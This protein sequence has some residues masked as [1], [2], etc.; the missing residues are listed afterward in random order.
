MS[1]PPRRTVRLRVLVV[2][3]TVMVLGF[4]LTGLVTFLLQ[5][6][7]LEDNVRGQLDQEVAELRTAAEYRAQDPGARTGV[8]N[9]LQAVT[10]SSAPSDHEAVLA[11][12]DGT[13]AYRPV[14]QDFDLA[15]PETLQQVREAYVPGRTVHTTLDVRGRTVRSVIASVRV[16]G[17]PAEGIFVVGIDVGPQHREIWQRAGA[18][19]AAAA[20]S[21]LIAGT[22]GALLIGRLLRPLETLRRAAE[23]VTHTDLSRRV[24]VPPTD[25][26]V[27]ALALT[28]NGMLERL[29][30]AFDG[31]RQF[32]RDAGHE[33]RTPLTVVQGTLETTDPD[34]P[35]DVRESREIALEELERMS[36]LVGDLSELARAGRPDFLTPR[37]VDLDLFAQSLL[38]RAEHLGGDHHWLLEDSP[39]GVAE[40]DDQRLAQ[41]VLQLA[42]NAVRYSPPGTTVTLGVHRR[43]ADRT[44]HGEILEVH[45]DDEGP[46][47][48]EHERERIFDRFA[49]G[50]GVTD[51]AGTGLGLP[52]VRAIA[53]AHGG[54]AHVTAA[55]GGGARFVLRVPSR[56]S[57]T[58]GATDDPHP[59]NPDPVPEPAPESPGERP[60]ENPD[61]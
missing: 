61:R 53:Q 40:F 2:M 54:S 12:V 5:V 24:P 36:R 31:Q 16:E 55:P 57:R 20:A 1:T 60:D 43:P 39:A 52:I 56:G 30:D 28:V 46:G 34:D 49:R 29:E 22:V 13:P 14:E 26:D 9:L 37:P 35:A 38:A 17:D 25:D 4:L 10:R 33:L 23:E 41:A 27:A 19:A 44:E 45:V 8:A 15:D 42:A 47:V 32:L 50:T 59:H 7:S 18:Y 21:V 6:R 11:I 58:D 51:T 48:P 3:L